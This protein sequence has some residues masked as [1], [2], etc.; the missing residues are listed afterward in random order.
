MLGAIILVVIT[1]G[2]KGTTPVFWK[3]AL[4]VDSVIT[5]ENAA[6]QTETHAVFPNEAGGLSVTH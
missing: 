6:V 5:S 2:S 3:E 4:I 1:L